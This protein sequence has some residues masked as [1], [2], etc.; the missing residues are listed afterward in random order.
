MKLFYIHYNS[1][2]P[3]ACLFFLSSAFLACDDDDLVNDGKPRILYVRVTN[4]DSSDSLL[5][6]GYQSNV[7]AII[8][9]NLQHTQA[10]WFNDQQAA[11]S[12]TYVTNTSVITTIPG[13]IPEDI[14]NTLRLIFANGDSL[15]YPF[16]VAISEP[17]V[18][19][20]KCEY[21]PAGEIATIRG[22]FFYAPL[23]VTF[24]GG[25][26][27]KIE[28]VDETVLEVEVPEG[29][30]P[31]PITVTTNFGETTSDF[32]FRD[33][34]NIFISSDPFT[35]WWN[36]SFVVSSPGTDAPPIINGNYIRV[37]Q[38]ISGWQWLEVAGGPPSAMGDISKNIPDEAIL[39]PED[40]FL[41]FELNTI[42]PY[43][44]NVIKI[45]VGLSHDF[46]NDAYRW[47]PP[48]DT[49]GT[50]QTVVLPLETVMADFDTS[51][52][53]DGYYTRI[54]FHG[55]GDLDCD[56]SFDNFR[57]VTKVLE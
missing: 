48:Y 57:V 51:V 21:V 12:P 44:G 52:S 43:N 4:P 15:L 10:V 27:G 11:L 55:A 9:N 3:L 18:K 5:V 25:V 29:A 20:M 6:A 24:T 38:A 46:N 17:L 37:K 53:A 32:W 22:D 49:Q 13:R 2:W 23:T 14:T 28:T 56:M 31:G 26:T 35:G 39:H 8:G 30:E 16:A 19:S 41:K 1:L 45:N 54:L 33:N 36:E 40:Y 34:R 7:V 50:W 47:L 42:K